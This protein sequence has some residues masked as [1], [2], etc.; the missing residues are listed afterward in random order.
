MSWWEDESL[1]GVCVSWVHNVPCQHENRICFLG[2]LGPETVPGEVEETLLSVRPLVDSFLLCEAGAPPL[3]S[4][5]VR[6]LLGAFGQSSQII[7]TPDPDPRSYIFRQAYENDLAQGADF[8]L[9]LDMGDT[10]KISAPLEKGDS[11]RVSLDPAVEDKEG[12]LRSLESPEQFSLVSLARSSSGLKPGEFLYTLA[13]A[14]NDRP[15]SWGSGVGEIGS[16][17]P[18]N[19]GKL[20]PALHIVEG[21]RDY[22]R[23]FSYSLAQVEEMSRGREPAHNPDRGRDLEAAYDREAAREPAH[24]PNRGDT[25]VQKKEP[26]TSN[27]EAYLALGNGLLAF[28]GELSARS[29]GKALDEAGNDEQEE[30]AVKGLLSSAAW[31]PEGRKVDWAVS[32]EMLEACCEKKRAEGKNPPAKLYL[33]LLEALAAAGE[34]AQTKKVARSAPLQGWKNKWVFQ[35]GAARIF[36]AAGEKEEGAFWLEKLIR[37]EEYPLNR[38]CEI[39]EIEKRLKS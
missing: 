15:Y 6:L 23:F 33:G 27:F 38:E 24:T 30:E 17:R 39:A 10:L 3:A 12:L 8:L 26:R 9:F 28:D 7:S 25:I 19:L 35:L 22:P 37:E 32:A 21:K 2:I 5:K 18:C 11:A 20:F 14:R 31:A 13:L 4:E 36:T 1:E 29:F 34:R 16:D